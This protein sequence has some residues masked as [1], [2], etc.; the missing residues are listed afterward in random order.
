MPKQRAQNP[1]YT[2][3]YND[4]NI[5]AGAQNIAQLL[6]GGA[7]PND[8]AEAES[9]RTLR[10]AQAGAATQTAGKTAAE[11][12]RLEFQNKRLFNPRDTGVADVAATLGLDPA[13]TAAVQTIIDQAGGFDNVLTTGDARRK[14][15]FSGAMNRNGPDVSDMLGLAPAQVAERQSALKG[16]APYDVSDNRV[17]S[18]F[19][20][21]DSLT[22]DMGR[23]Q[24]AKTGA[25]QRKADAEAAAAPIKAEK[26]RAMP[27]ASIKQLNESREALRSAE[28]MQ[29][30]LAQTRTLVNGEE[31]K[32][33]PL[34]TGPIDRVAATF[35]NF[36]G[37][38]N[39]NSKGLLAL[40]QQREKLRND[41][42]MLAKGV[43]TEGDALRAL[44]AMMPDTN[45]PDAIVQQLNALE[46]ASKRLQEIH[47]ESVNQIEYE[48]GRQKTV[49]KAADVAPATPPAGNRKLDVYDASGKKVGTVSPQN[50]GNLPPGHTAR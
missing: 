9:E 19:D 41:Y 50:V 46:A 4:P 34:A 42:L 3:R 12:E 22:T 26:E 13:S 48:Y 45:D 38:G 6:L 2:G 11:R 23:A 28:G 36:T 5:A 30:T 18:K 29:A 35:R 27:P 33:A 40:K 10:E 25:E 24:I 21:R 31:G 32:A 37:D 17:Q 43:Q 47:L 39:E 8:M 14:N 15:E 1:L 7:S 16:D 20:K 44:N 49:G